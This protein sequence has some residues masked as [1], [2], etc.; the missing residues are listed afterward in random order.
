M[1]QR[2]AQNTW[3]PEYLD[4]MSTYPRRQQEQEGT[5]PQEKLD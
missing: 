5:T 1:K 3:Q 2:G 4:L